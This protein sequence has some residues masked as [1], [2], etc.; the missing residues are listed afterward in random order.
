[1]SQIPGLTA[2]V[3]SEAE[4][5]VTRCV[6]VEVASQGWTTGQALANLREALEPYFEDEPAPRH[7][8][9]PSSQ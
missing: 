5:F 4:W 3:V 8:P 6:E 9:S 1:M 2:T 7:C